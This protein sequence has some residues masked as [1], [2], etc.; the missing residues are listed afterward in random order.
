M[1]PRSS[2]EPIVPMDLGNMRSLGVH[3]LTVSCETCHHETVVNVDSW[4]DHMTVPSFG[5]RMVCTRCGASGAEVR[6]NWKEYNPKRM[7]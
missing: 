6:P 2:S 3:S 1:T 7:G 4:P 5:P